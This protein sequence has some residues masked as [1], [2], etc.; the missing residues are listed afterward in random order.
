M[1][2]AAGSCLLVRIK[3]R[4]EYVLCL[5]LSRLCSQMG[6][7][8]LWRVWRKSSVTWANTPGYLNVYI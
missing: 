8:G 1:S 5:L 4:L 7:L 6:F 2:E 3:L